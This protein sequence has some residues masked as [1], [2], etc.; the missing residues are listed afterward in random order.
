MEDSEKKL[1]VAEP[2]EEVAEET[3][4]VDEKTQD[5]PAEEFTEQE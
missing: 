5:E 2:V 3:T 4:V 1:E